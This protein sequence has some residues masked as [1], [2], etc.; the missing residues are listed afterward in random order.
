VNCVSG[1]RACV[2]F[3]GEEGGE[4]ALLLED[5]PGDAHTEEGVTRVLHGCYKGFTRG[6]RG[7]YEGVTRV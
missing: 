3:V 6:L 4:L 1:V 5:L 7:C 2:A